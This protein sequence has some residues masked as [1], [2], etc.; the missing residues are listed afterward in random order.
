M[1]PVPEPGAVLAGLCAERPTGRGP[2]PFL[3]GGDF[4]LHGEPPRP[5]ILMG[6]SPTDLHIPRWDSTGRSEFPWQ[7][8]ARP[9]L[10]RLAAFVSSCTGEPVDLGG[11]PVPLGGGIVAGW[12]GHELPATRLGRHETVLVWDTSA[13][14]AFMIAAPR[15]E[16]PAAEAAREA[17]A[18]GAAAARRFS[19]AAERG[20]E[21]VARW[22]DSSAPGPEFSAPVTP[23]AHAARVSEVLGQI[24]A[25]EVYQVNLAHPIHLPVSS[26][27]PRDLARMFLSLWDRNPVPYPTFVKIGDEVVIALTPE[28]YIARRGE[29]LESR[30]IK[31][32]RPRGEGPESDRRLARELLASPKDR[33]ENV[34]IVDLVR[35]D[36]GRVAVPGQVHVRRLCG[37]ETFATV[38]HL[39]STVSSRLRADVGL[40]D[41]LAATHPP[42][43]MTGAPKIRAVEMLAR[44]EGAPRGPYAGGVGWFAGESDFHL[45]MVIRGLVAGPGGAVLQ[46]GGG[47]VADSDPLEEYR[48]TLHKARSI[49]GDDTGRPVK[50]SASSP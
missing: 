9:L 26:L 34:M 11:R 32:T 49:L 45:A 4:S 44:L 41:I 40:A 29:R 46:V 39:V 3:L 48:E 24:A 42:G 19:D 16:L 14:S 25:G 31:G 47:I 28:R 5:L 10:E 12:I 27:A 43:S 20:A 7:P 50:A 15:R 8:G 36:L 35:N 33:A 30:P 1:E 17:R 6:D 37:L 21:L 13:G 18:R 23:V 22:S 2:E 38:H